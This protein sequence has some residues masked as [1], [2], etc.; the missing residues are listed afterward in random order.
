ATGMNT[1][2]IGIIRISGDDSFSVVKKI[3]TLPSGQV[4]EELESH[5]VYYGYIHDGDQMIDEVLLIPLRSPRSFTK[6]DTIEIDCH[7][8]LLVMDR[9]LKLVCR[10]GARPAEPGEFTKRAFLNGRI[11]LSEAEAVIDLIRSKNDLAMD[12]SLR[13]LVGG[14][15]ERLDA[16]KS[17]IVHEIARI[18][19]ALDDPEHYDL[20]GYSDELRK[21]TN[22]WIRDLTELIDSYKEGRIVTEGIRTVI[23]GK[24]NVGKSSFLNTLLGTERAIVTEIAGTTRDSIE[25]EIVIGG[26]VLKV[27]DTAGVH[28]TEDPVESIGVERSIRLMEDAD[29]ILMVI[30]SSASLDHSDRK[31]LSMIRDKKA[32]ILLNKSDLSPLVTEEEIRK[33]TDHEII[34]VSAKEHQGFDAFRNYITNAFL[35]GR[36]SYNDE[37]FISNQRQYDLLTKSVNS[38]RNVLCSIDQNMPEDCFSIDLNDAYEQLCLLTGERMN[39]DVINEVFSKF[40]MGK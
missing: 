38:L 11:D 35:E 2:G 14:L 19:A 5:R 22:A 13:H 40:C 23:L 36:I 7:G 1:A 30:D 18:E 28:D 10:N 24:P 16:C 34:S 12:N 6:E 4:P 37:I 27:I 17:Q 3:F 21:K 15:K 33:H 39:D 9:I 31:L 25:E 29:L 26:I 20:D 8:G 32:L